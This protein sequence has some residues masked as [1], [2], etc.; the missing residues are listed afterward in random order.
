M[1]YL[2][3][4]VYALAQ[5]FL[6]LLIS[7]ALH[8]P[9]LFFLADES[10]RATG[11]ESFLENYPNLC[12]WDCGFYHYLANGTDFITNKH[13]AAFFPLFPLTLKFAHLLFPNLPLDSLSIILSNLF[14]VI[15]I[16]LVIVLGSYLWPNT[17]QKQRWIWT[18]GGLL[19]GLAVAA[20]PYSQFSSYGYPESLFTGLFAACLIFILKKKWRTAGF[21]CGLVSITRPQGLWI[22]GVFI[23][24]LAMKFIFEQKKLHKVQFRK[25][26][27]LIK[28]FLL[29]GVIAVIP[30]ILFILWQKHTFGDPLAFLKAQSNWGRSFHLIDGFKNNI[31]KFD[32]P[33]MFNVLA[34][35]ACFQYLRKRES[36]YQFLGMTILLMTEI[37]LFFGG[38]LSYARFTALNLGVFIYLIG[39]TSNRFWL[40]IT[41][42]IFAITRLNIEI[43]SWLN[44]TFFCF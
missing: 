7:L 30:F 22:L 20:Y 32:W 41:L 19:L 29:P 44:T 43:H 17:E 6:L 24:T 31:P 4:A 34:I 16:A 38:F 39:I 15:S 37:P 2:R 11:K 8:Y 35:F 18:R 3:K 5:I 28:E 36:F 1:T 9:R 10:F 33:R 40:L 12:K 21:V 26:A 13:I 25:N 27:V 42:L 23:I 14:S